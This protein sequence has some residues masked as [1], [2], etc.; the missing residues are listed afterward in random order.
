MR[1]RSG[2]AF[3][4]QSAQTIN[5]EP[6]STE[7]QFALSTHRRFIIKITLHLED[8]RVCSKVPES[9]LS[10]ASKALEIIQNTAAQGP[11][12]RLFISP[13]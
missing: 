11:S 2:Q 13:L 7:Y 10:S 1:F 9:Y 6:L 4:K 12:T 3:V 5:P 8:C